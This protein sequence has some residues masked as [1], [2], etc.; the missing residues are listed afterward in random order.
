MRNLNIVI[1]ILKFQIRIETRENKIYVNMRN[2]STS[3][4]FPET[5]NSRHYTVS[6]RQFRRFEK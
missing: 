4:R 1:F 5:E 2:F 3:Y 6:S